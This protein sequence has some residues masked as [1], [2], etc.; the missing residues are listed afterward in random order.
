MFETG[1][2]SDYDLQELNNTR[3]ILATSIQNEADN[4]NVLSGNWDPWRLPSRWKPTE[5]EMEPP[6]QWE[7]DVVREYRA[8]K[9]AK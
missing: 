5:F 7:I 6:D 9:K 2:S 4:L 8:A 3:L 1:R